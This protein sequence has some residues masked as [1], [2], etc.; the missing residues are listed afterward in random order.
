MNE[1]IDALKKFRD[2]RD[3]QQFHNPKDLSLALSIEAGELLEAFLWKQPE[4]ADKQKIR[5]ELAD[6]F[7]FAFLL[8]DA[9]DLDVKDIVLAK[10][11]QN[12]EKYP[13]SKAKGTA[14]KY[15]E[16]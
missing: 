7:A 12:E 16:L 11:K 4:E 1:I 10:I 15:N 8:A 14:R 2:E 13:V 5:E 6:V 3:W 9:C